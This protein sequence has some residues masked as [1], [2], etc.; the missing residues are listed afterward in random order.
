MAQDNQL[1]ALAQSGRQQIERSI[2]N[3]LDANPQGLRSA[4]IASYLDLYLQGSQNF[5]IYSILGGMLSRSVIIRNE[6]SK[7]FFSRNGRTSD[8]ELAQAGLGQI[9]AAILELLAVN[10]EGMRNAEIARQLGLSSDFRGSH[11]DYLTW[12]VL[13][14]LVSRGAVSRDFHTRAFTLTQN[15]AAQPEL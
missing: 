7:L 15:G 12:S 2:L 6:E 9:E 4:D 5:F 14:M 10:P 11:Q 8:E 13:T 3:L 1:Y